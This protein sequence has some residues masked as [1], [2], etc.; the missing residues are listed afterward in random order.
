M[1][2]DRI[3]YF[4][5]PLYLAG[6][7]M[8]F[9]LSMGHIASAADRIPAD[10]VMIDYASQ[11]LQVITTDNEVMAAFPTI[12]EVEDEITSIQI[13]QWDIY[14]SEYMEEQVDGRNLI[15]I[16]L[17]TINSTKG[18]YVAVKTDATS[19][20]YLIHINGTNT[21]LA[22]TYDMSEKL[23][24]I[25][26][27]ADD[28]N[29]CDSIFEYR[30]QYGNWA[31]Y[32]DEVSLQRYEQQGATLY[33]REKCGYDDGDEY[34]SK[35]RLS[36]RAVAN[37]VGAVAVDPSFILYEAVSTFSGNE[38][39]VKIPKL[40][41]GPSVALNYVKRTITVKKGCEYRTDVTANFKK[42]LNGNAMAVN[43]GNNAGI[44]EVRTTEKVT[45]SKYTPPSKITRYEYPATRT[46]EVSED[47]SGYVGKKAGKL[48]INYNEKTKKIECVS[49]DQENTYLVYVKQSGQARPIAGSA[50]LTTIKP[51]TSA[52]IP[53]VVTLAKSKMP[54]GSELYVAYAAD[55]KNKK[56][57]TEPVLLGVV[58]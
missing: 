23:V 30:T 39:K 27:R 41:V 47:E 35:G 26:D 36:N 25:I 13:K 37:K 14:D 33:F 44:L 21:K 45:K 17:S 24:S 10:D 53:K 38:I 56:W 11:T 19:E 4:L 52:S 40:S 20:A 9:A 29:E 54:S 12:K 49:L 58:K 43:I 28:N 50:A 8:T 34:T 51:T 3:G 16:D 18:G 31:D 48:S 42:T 5:R 46:L 7:M 22:G 15:N 55:A 57:A 1:R 6:I 32:N 2:K